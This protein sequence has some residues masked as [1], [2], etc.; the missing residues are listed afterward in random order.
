MNTHDGGGG[1]SGRVTEPKRS[2]LQHLWFMSVCVSP[3]NCCINMGPI[4]VEF[5]YVYYLQLYSD[6]SAEDTFCVCGFFFGFFLT[7]K[8]GV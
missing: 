3:F 2:V 6:W 1:L 4:Y 7:I 8:E 5:I